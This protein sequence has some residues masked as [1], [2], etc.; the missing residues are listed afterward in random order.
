[1]RVSTNSKN[2]SCRIF[3]FGDMTVPF[4]DELRRLL[5]INGDENLQQFFD[6]VRIKLQEEILYLPQ[7]HQ[8]LFPRFRSI[9]ELLSESE[10]PDRR[11]LKFTLFCI[12]ELAQF[13]RHFDAI[14]QLY[15]SPS[16]SYVLGF[17]AGS[18]TAA[19][20]SVSQTVDELVAVAVQTVLVANRTAL[21]LSMLRDGIPNHPFLSVPLVHNSD[22]TRE[23]DGLFAENEF[24]EYVL[25][26]AGAGG[27][28]STGPHSSLRGLLASSREVCNLLSES[29]HRISPRDIN[30]TMGEFHDRKA[31]RYTPHV[32][33]LSSVS[34]QFIP[35]ETCRG[36][37]R[38]V[39]SEILPGQIQD[40]D[41][42]SFISKS[43]PHRSFESCSIYSSSSE[44][45]ELLAVELRRNTDMRADIVELSDLEGPEPFCQ[46]VPVEYPTIAVVGYAS[47]LP[48]AI[49]GASCDGV[50]WNPRRLAISATHEALE[51]AGMVLDRTPSTQA[52]RVSVFFDGTRASGGWVQLNR[53]VGENESIAE[54][55]S[56]CFGFSGPTLDVNSHLPDSDALHTA[57]EYI[58][59]GECDTA[60]ASGAGVEKYYKRFSRPEQPNILDNYN[61]LDGWD[62][63][64]SRLDAVGAVIL[65]RLD[66]AQA[67]ND[68]ILGTITRRSASTWSWPDSLTGAPE[69][70]KTPLREQYIIARAEPREPQGLFDPRALQLVAVAAE[71]IE[72][73]K[74]NLNS[75]VDVLKPGIIDD[76]LLSALS[77]TTTARRTHHRY[78]LM[79]SGTT[80]A[81]IREAMERYQCNPCP[82]PNPAPKIAFVFTDAAD[83]HNGFAGELFRSDSHFRSDI[84]FLD[85]VARSHEFFFAKKKKNRIHSI[86]PLIEGIFPLLE[87]PDT[88][89]DEEELERKLIVRRLTVTCVQIALFRLWVSW[90]IK[91]SA[92]FSYGHGYYAAKHVAGSSISDII[93]LAGK[94]S[95]R[96]N[97][98]FQEVIEAGMASS[99][100]DK[101][102]IWVEIGPVYSCEAMISSAIGAEPLTIPSLNGKID[103]WET[104]AHGLSE[105]YLRGVNIN[106]N[107]YHRDYRRGHKL[108][109]LPG[110]HWGLTNDWIHDNDMSVTEDDAK[111]VNLCDANNFPTAQE[112]SLLHSPARTASPTD[113]WE[114]LQVI[115][116]NGSIPS[117]SNSTPS[118]NNVYHP[119]AKSPVNLIDFIEDE[120]S[121]TAEDG[122]DTPPLAN[123]PLQDDFNSNPRQ[124]DLLDAESILDW[125][126][127][128]HQPTT[129]TPTITTTLIH[130]S[131]KTD[132]EPRS[133][134]LFPPD[135]EKTTP[136]PPLATLRPEVFIYSLTSPH[137]D[138][139]KDSQTH[140]PTTANH[141]HAI[142]HIQPSGPYYLAGRS[143]GAIVALE[144]ARKLAVERGAV[145]WALLIDVK[146]DLIGKL[147][148]EGQLC[149]KGG[150]VG[151]W[152]LFWE[153]T[154]GVGHVGPVYGELVEGDDVR[155][156]E[157]MGLVVY[158]SQLMGWDSGGVGGVGNVM[159][160]EFGEGYGE[161]GEGG[162]VGLGVW[163]LR[164][165]V[166]EVMVEGVNGDE[167]GIDEEEEEEDIDEDDEEWEL[168]E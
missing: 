138:T 167:E 51:L 19:A 44:V 107:Q 156:A 54:R 63:D 20:V 149:Q 140:T 34:A 120:Q 142:Q 109:P 58:W 7:H 134:F 21:R 74:G 24:Q 68:P 136:A 163:G 10:G 99:A 86:L 15:P 87:T 94:N 53:G 161:K 32:P 2:G 84:L 27:S 72:L 92:V 132:T 118:T 144:A 75:L 155:A 73:L 29:L 31:A 160:V 93:Y 137:P 111:I 4:E 97:V 100:I 28:K 122:T 22:G 106:W 25:P 33:M 18:F 166:E 38:R 46:I 128:D 119:T 103:P 151:R 135:H 153:G 110:C 123:S 85:G 80:V 48:I 81:S 145:V 55:V 66:E 59:R 60:I 148:L 115:E 102:T 154:D 159:V 3:V 26:N 164:E 108:L 77:Y 168:A 43:L 9:A 158:L 150:I 89:L 62:D 65:K 90:G 125:E 121:S 162:E 64:Y 6:Q 37:H 52:D 70:Y 11:V 78:R 117:P 113:S 17:G 42:G 14:Q 79:F 61:F 139:P 50:R 88:E 40:N 147:L 23:I 13:I 35:A 36:L 165:F 98:N 49:P 143:A 30:H 82:I 114:A 69:Y 47:R 67:D 104:L 146:P 12:W 129:P 105:L 152:P 126:H 157:G 8:K 16:E 39:V 1:M 5:Q 83:L 76:K 130:G 124:H 71:S 116:L 96:E 131:P 95:C 141:I 56:K 127:I 57:C 101:D 91:P 41:I 45:A 112:D 133:L